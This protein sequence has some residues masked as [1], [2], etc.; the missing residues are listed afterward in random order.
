MIK[1]NK[2]YQES[3]RHEVQQ[4]IS[5]RSLVLEHYV[6]VCL[7]GVRST[8]S[9]FSNKHSVR[10]FYGTCERVAIGELEY[11]C[12]FDIAHVHRLIVVYFKYWENK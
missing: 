7:F 11:F 6:D 8:F 10:A 1:Y 2:N 9:F 3:V 5:E 4:W 12:D